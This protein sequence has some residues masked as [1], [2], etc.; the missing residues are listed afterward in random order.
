M[1]NIFMMV[2]FVSPQASVY[3]VFCFFLVSIVTIILQLEVILLESS[4]VFGFFLFFFGTYL[5]SEKTC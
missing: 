4:E 5:T 2:I 3:N 1:Y